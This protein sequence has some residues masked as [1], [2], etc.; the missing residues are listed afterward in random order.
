M[1]AAAC[2]PQID[3]ALCKLGSARSIGVDDPT[4]EGDTARAL[5]A[6]AAGPWS[7]T[8]MWI[9]TKSPDPILQLT[10]A[11][12]TTTR[13]DISVSSTATSAKYQTASAK[14]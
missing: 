14:K 2:G 6:R 13:I 8:M 12:G 5:I 3:P 4:P 10:P 1:A 11:A 9:G 7:G